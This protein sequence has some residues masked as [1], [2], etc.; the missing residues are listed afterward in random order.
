[1]QDISFMLYVTPS[2][3]RRPNRPEIRVTWNYTEIEGYIF[4]LILTLIY[5]I[6]RIDLKVSSCDR[7]YFES[8]MTNE[9]NLRISCFWDMSWFRLGSLTYEGS[10][11]YFLRI[12]SEST[13]C[14]K[15]NH[16]QEKATV[17][18]VEAS[19]IFSNVYVQ[20][21]NNTVHLRQLLWAKCCEIWNFKIFSLEILIYIVN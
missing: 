9:M 11:R 16:I 8:Q 5:E 4:A 3:T 15:D 17:S 6:C 19:K 14:K 21:W 2:F 10:R 12:V 20:I 7:T 1:V 13:S 18:S